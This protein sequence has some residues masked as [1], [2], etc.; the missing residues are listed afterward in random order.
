MVRGGCCCG[1]GPRPP[2]ACTS[3]CRAPPLGAACRRLN[4]PLPVFH[5][6]L[7]DLLPM[8]LAPNCITLM[9]TASIVAA[10]ILNALYLPDFSGERASADCY[11]LALMIGRYLRDRAI[12]MEA[13]TPGRFTPLQARRRAGSMFSRVPPWWRTS[14]WTAWMASR[15]AAPAAPRPWASCLTTAVMPWCCT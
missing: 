15:P 8:W 3:M 1:G 4:L 6:V 7:V 10:Y 14:T 2:P 13:I 5:K 11:Q 9:A 12:S